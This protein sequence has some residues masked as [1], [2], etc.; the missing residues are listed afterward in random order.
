M[1]EK[2]AAIFPLIGYVTNT[3]SLPRKAQICM[4]KSL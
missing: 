2:P 1:G 4:K 3:T